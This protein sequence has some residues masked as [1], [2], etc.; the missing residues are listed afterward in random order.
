MSF[1]PNI[2]LRKRKTPQASLKSTICQTTFILVSFHWI[3]FGSKSIGLTKF[4][5]HTHALSLSP[6]WCRQNKHKDPPLAHSRFDSHFQL[7]LWPGS[8]AL[9]EFREQMKY[10]GGANHVCRRHAVEDKILAKFIISAC[11]FVCYIC[12]AACSMRYLLH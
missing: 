6:K 10:R 3:K 7:F 4:S 1:L 9:E 5:N 2:E 11:L 8:L 12:P